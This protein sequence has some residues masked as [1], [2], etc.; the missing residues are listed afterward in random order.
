MA[1]KTRYQ[2][3][4][5]SGDYAEVRPRSE[6]SRWL[7]EVVVTETGGLSKDESTSVILSRA[8]TI[9]LATRL[10]NHALHGTW[11]GTND[12]RT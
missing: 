5:A 8:D 11:E 6:D 12:E 1:V 2:C 10:L 3:R 4:A 9:D 7:I